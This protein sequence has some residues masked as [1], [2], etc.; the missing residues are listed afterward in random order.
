MNVGKEIIMSD[1]FFGAELSLANNLNLAISRETTF[2]TSILTPG[3]TQEYGITQS[4]IFAAYIMVISAFTT[5]LIVRLKDN[6]NIQR[7]A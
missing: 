1:F 4:F 2:M 5:I 7:L 3:I 6:N